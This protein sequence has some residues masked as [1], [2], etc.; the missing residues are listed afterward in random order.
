[1]GQSL[2]VAHALVLLGQSVSEPQPMDRT[3]TTSS[4]K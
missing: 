2:S 3:T 4:Q 1:L